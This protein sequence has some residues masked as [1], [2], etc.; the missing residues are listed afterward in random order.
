[1]ESRLFALVRLSTAWWPVETL[2]LLTEGWCSVIAC[3]PSSAAPA[4]GRIF[5][6][7]LFFFVL[8][9]AWEECAHKQLR[10]RSNLR[11]TVHDFLYLAHR[12]YDA[13]DSAHPI[14]D[15]LDVTNGEAA[16]FGLCSLG[17]D[18]GNWGFCCLTKWDD[19]GSLYRRWRYE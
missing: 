2:A 17:Y 3:R 14:N 7:F 4:L 19:G 10:D 8:L 18:C 5:N 16:F 6:F 9:F 1:M 12:F 11:Y 13:I 15:L